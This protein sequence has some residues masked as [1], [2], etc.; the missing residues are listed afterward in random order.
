MPLSLTHTPCP[1]L[2]HPPQTK[3]N[4]TLRASGFGSK[5]DV[6]GSFADKVAKCG[7]VESILSFASFRNN[8]ELKKG[9]GAKR[10][11]LTGGQKGE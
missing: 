7:V 11:R 10:S 4:L 9:D 6:S 3:E 2:P 8:K 1:V 5:C